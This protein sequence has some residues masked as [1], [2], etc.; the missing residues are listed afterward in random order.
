MP[1]EGEVANQNDNQQQTSVST[2]S[3]KMNVELQM[4]SDAE[5][6]NK[7]NA[8]SDFENST[9][10]GNEELPNGDMH[11]NLNAERT[12]METRKELVLAKYV[13]RNHPTNQIIENKEAKPMT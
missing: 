3:Q 13:R 4:H 9:H 6:H 1:N 10:E 2:K 11:G 12:N 5:L 7:K 8:H